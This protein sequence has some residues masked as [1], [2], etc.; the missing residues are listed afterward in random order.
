MKWKQIASTLGLFSLILVTG[1]GKDL[2]QRATVSGKVTNGGEPVPGAKVSFYST[3]EAGGKAGA[4]Y[5]AQTD[6]SGTY[7]ISGIGNEVGIPPGMY[8]VTVVKLDIKGN[9]PPDFDAGQME[10]SGAAKNILPRDYENPATTKLSV[11]L[12]IGKNEN[13]NLELKAAAKK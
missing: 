1:C 10:A 11:T 6:S 4:S 3:A 8:K 5:S 2:G 12:D 13:K 9:L 7:V